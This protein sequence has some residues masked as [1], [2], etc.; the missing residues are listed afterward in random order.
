MLLGDG[1]DPIGD[2]NY[3]YDDDY[4]GGDDYVD[5]NT[6]DRDDYGVWSME[7]IVMDTVDSLRNFHPSQPNPL[8]AFKTVCGS[9]WQGRSWQTKA[10]PGTVSD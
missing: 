5:D 4:N 8:I 1:T 7:M 9:L 6:G 3:N 10:E 2:C